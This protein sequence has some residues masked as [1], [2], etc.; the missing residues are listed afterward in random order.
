MERTPKRKAKSSRI[1][2][3]SAAIPSSNDSRNL[4]NR[5]EIA[6]SRKIVS[7]GDYPYCLARNVDVDSVLPGHPSEAAEL[8]SGYNYLA[9]SHTNLIIGHRTPVLAGND[10][11]LN[12]IVLESF[13]VPTQ[14]YLVEPN[15]NQ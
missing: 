6:K 9:I 1:L 11:A 13:R 15:D 2:S 12:H 7:I 4:P 5:I 10:F 14:A 8:V 3:V